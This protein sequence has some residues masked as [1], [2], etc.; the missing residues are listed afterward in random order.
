MSGRPFKPGQSGNPAGRPP[1][2]KALTDIL[3]KALSRTVPTN[4]GRVAGKRVLARLV[5]EGLTTGK[6]TFPGDEKPSVIGIKDW[7]ELAK[8]AYQYLEPPTTRTEHTGA[9]GGAIIIDWG[10]NAASED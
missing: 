5:A 9:D 6:I 2:H 8:W 1:K 3:N 7:M 4:T 10:D